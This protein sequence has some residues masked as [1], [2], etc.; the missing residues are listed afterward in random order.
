MKFK[1]KSKFLPTGDQP[2]AIEKLTENLKSGVKHQTLLGVTG[3]GK[4]FTIANVIEKIQKP[5]LVIAHNKTLAAQLV[6]EFREFFPG[7]AVHYFVSYYDYYQPEAYIPSTDTY[8]EKD[9]SINDEIDRLR[10]AAT[11]ALLTRKDVIIV[12]SVSCIYGIGSPELYRS[13]NFVLEVGK[14]IKRDDFLNH[15]VNQRYSRNDFE[16]KRGAFRLKGDILE[17]FP[18]YSTNPIKIEF[19]GDKIERISEIDWITGLKI[20]DFESYEVFPATHFVIPDNL[21]RDAVKR[22][23]KDLD[24]RVKYFKK[25][26]KLLEAQRIE[27]RTKYDLEMMETTSHCKGIENYSRYFDGRKP[28]ESPNVLIDF[29]PKD[30][31]MVIDESHMTVPQINGM[32]AGDLARKKKLIDFGFRLPSAYDNRPL[33]FSEFYSKTNQ[34]IFT[35]ATPSKYEVDISTAKNIVEQLVR[36]TGLLDPKIEVR[37]PEGQIEN[38]ISEVK[39]VV[40]KGERAI[41]TTL[42][43]K[44]AEEL[45]DFLKDKSMKV[46]YLHSDIDTLERSKILHS[47]RLGEFDVL[48]GINLLREGIDLPEVSLIGILDADKEGFLRSKTALVQIIGRAARHINGKVIMYALNITGSMKDAISETN[49]RRKYQDKYNIEHKITP[50]G[51]EKEVKPKIDEEERRLEEIDRSYLKLPKSEKRQIISELTRAMNTAARNLEFER[52]AKLRDEI[53][54]LEEKLR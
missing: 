52:A 11:H 17:I 43:K 45:T 41:I 28:G 12:A 48:V 14:E 40:A 53:S 4:T 15:L 18:A 6:D 10:H 29:F 47:L 25:Q 2:K 36:P 1:L 19:F 20:K 32:Y 9:S 39:S 5:T 16:I 49:R 23:K 8:I 21:H 35:S 42:T 26:N 51:I 50:R 31:L 44:M 38:L 27:E 37:K 3:S 24:E 34:V 33:R 46:A 7:N 30:F 22:I 13:Q 54:L